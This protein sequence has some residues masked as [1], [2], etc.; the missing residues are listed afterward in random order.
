MNNPKLIKEKFIKACENLDPRIIEDYLDEHLDP[1]Y[2]PPREP[3]LI[4]G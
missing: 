3:R 2:S 1:R 4:E